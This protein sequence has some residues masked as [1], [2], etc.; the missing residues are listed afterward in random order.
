[1]RLAFDRVK[2]WRLPAAERKAA[3]QERLAEQAIRR[4]RDNEHRAERRAA[5]LESE[6]RRD[7]NYFGQGGGGN[8]GGPG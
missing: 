2:E 1:M 3:R 8:I 7:S 6:A 4:E 5:A